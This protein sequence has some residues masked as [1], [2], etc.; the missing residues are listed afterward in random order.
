MKLREKGCCVKKGDGVK[1]GILCKKRE[2][3]CKNGL[4]F[5]EFFA[6]FI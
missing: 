6:I 3:V 1:K 2:D 4:L 5:D